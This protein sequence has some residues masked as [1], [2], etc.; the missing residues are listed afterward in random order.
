MCIDWHTVLNSK[1]L[2]EFIGWGIELKAHDLLYVGDEVL[3]M[4]NTEDV[5]QHDVYD[6]LHVLQLAYDLI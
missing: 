3:R 1:H 6:D 4:W 2:N 5:D